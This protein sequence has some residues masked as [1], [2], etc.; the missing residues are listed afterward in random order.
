MAPEL[1]IIIVDKAIAITAVF[2]K[3]FFTLHYA[4]WADMLFK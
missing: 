4:L 2:N 3:P 1:L